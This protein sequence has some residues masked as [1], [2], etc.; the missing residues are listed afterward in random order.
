MLFGSDHQLFAWFELMLITAAA[1][2]IWV[3][4]ATLDYDRPQQYFFWPML[5]PVLIAQSRSMPQIDPL[6]SKHFYRPGD[7]ASQE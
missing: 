5:G 7:D 2:L 6:T 3:Y 4:Q 1:I